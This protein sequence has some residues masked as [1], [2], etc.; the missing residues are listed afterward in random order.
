[1]PHANDPSLCQA[2]ADA[3]ASPAFLDAMGDLLARAEREWTGP[4]CA[5]R[6]CGR[7]CDFASAGHRLYVSTGELA[8]LAGAGP[9]GGTVAPLR[10]PFHRDGQCHARTAR[11]LG[12]RM[13]FCQAP[14]RQQGEQCYERYHAELRRLHELHRVPYRYLELTEGLRQI[15][16]CLKTH[17]AKRR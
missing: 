3:L 8:L 15:A 2:V 14:A 16:N 7:C 11:S 12:C 10:C 9:G 1:M 17:P 5:C 4:D 6:A 13:Y